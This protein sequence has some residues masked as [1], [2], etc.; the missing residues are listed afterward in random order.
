VSSQTGKRTVAGTID[1]GGVYFSRVAAGGGFAFL[2][3]TPVDD[4]GQFPA[5]ARP[6]APYEGS[7]TAQARAQTR[8]IFDGY[9]DLLPRVG[10]SVQNICQLE[11][12]VKL[13]TH[14]DPYFQVA[15]GPGYMDMGGPTAATAEVGAYFPEESVINLTGWAIIPDEASGFVKRYP[16]EDPANNPGRV[17]KP[18]VQAGPYVMT[19]Y[20]PTDNKVGLDPAVRVP[21]W[22][23]RGVEIR[24]E[25]QLGVEVLRKR[26]DELGSSLGDIVN[27]TLFL[28]DPA[29]LYDFD[30]TLREA[31]GDAPA[32]TRMVIPTR[33]FA[34]PR[35]EGAFGHEQ[36]AARMEL[37]VRAF[38]AGHGAHKTVVAGPGDGF[39]YQSAGVRV[40]PL[41]W[42]SNQVAQAIQRGD[43]ARELDN[44][45]AQ[46]AETC[47][48][49]GTE[50][51]NLLRLRA[52]VRRPSDALAVYSA[53]KKVIPSNPPTVS[54][55]AVGD[56]LD[57][58]GAS[59]ALDAVAFVDQA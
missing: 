34:N 52:V 16:G 58:S 56:Q 51:A 14:A 3:G 25:A 42:V 19:T 27:Y 48:N 45:L 43:L 1:A 23:W 47:Q 32:P 22:N 12:Y 15:L 54:I 41:L 26:L 36:G 11:Q 28:A 33:G 18:I 21:D 8:F 30:E 10:T 17:F 20:F 39:G 7:A 4:N 6:P 31:L 35:R 2:A 40:G 57:I 55:M 59:V 9:R 13:K 44:V 50:L 5:A 49:A 37:Q 38:R 53:V 29:D 24:S 46:I